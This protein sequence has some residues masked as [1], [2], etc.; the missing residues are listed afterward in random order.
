MDENQQ[1]GLDY[2]RRAFAVSGQDVVGL[3]DHQHSVTKP[4]EH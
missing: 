4:S 1:A 2:A 3:M